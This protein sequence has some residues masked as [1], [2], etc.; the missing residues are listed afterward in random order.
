MSISTRTSGGTRPSQTEGIGGGR[1]GGGGWVLARL[2]DGGG[3]SAA[4][5]WPEDAVGSWCNWIDLERGEAAA[6]GARPGSGWRDDANGVPRGAGAVDDEGRF[7]MGGRADDLGRTVSG[8]R[9]MGLR[10]A[11]EVLLSE[12]KWLWLRCVGNRGSVEGG[13]YTW[14]DSMGS[15]GPTSSSKGRVTESSANPAA[16]VEATHS[17]V[18]ADGDKLAPNSPLPL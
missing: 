13:R 11:A 8:G 18:A 14:G 17:P 4:E 12:A 15:M 3:G 7:W 5:G 2:E 6:E 10:A 9:E 1:C 16:R